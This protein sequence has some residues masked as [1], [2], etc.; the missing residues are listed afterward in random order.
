MC[1]PGLGHGSRTSGRVGVDPGVDNTVSCIRPVEP[2]AEQA[3]GPVH[4]PPDSVPSA[5]RAAASDSPVRIY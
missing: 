4:T 2:R 1:H 5:L 3:T